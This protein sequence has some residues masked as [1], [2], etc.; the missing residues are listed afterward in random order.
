MTT[1]YVD[2]YAGIAG[3]MMLGALV[4][5]GV[6]ESVIRE[7][8][9]KIPLDGY[10][11]RFERVMRG[12]L[13]GT[14]A[15]VDVHA[16]AHAHADEHRR[17]GHGHGH[18][19]AH[20]GDHPHRHYAEIRAMLE[21]LPSVVKA[22]ARAIFDRLAAVEAKLHG[23]TVDEVAFH[24][25]G[26]VDSI[27]DIVGAAAGLAWLNPARV[28]V[29]R[30]P[31]G[32][33]AVKTAHGMLPVPAPATMALLAEAGALV[34]DGGLAVEL[35]TPTGAAILAASA[36]AYGPPPAMRVRA[37]GW[38]AGDRELADRPNLLRLVVGDDEPAAESAEIVEIAANVDDMNPELYEP[39]LAALFAAGAVDAW[40]TPIVMKKGRPAITVS[41]LA[42]VAAAPS[43]RAALLAE[44]TTLGVRWRTLARETLA[45]RIVEVDTRFGRV[46]V[47]LGERDG[48]VTHVAPEYE[49]CRTR[50]SEAGVPT[51]SVWAAAL[52]AAEATFGGGQKA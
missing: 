21:G 15:I 22:R 8:L 31:L 37:T 52:A 23:T 38:G 17:D 10:S 39:L 48:V 20:L 49:S 44:S 18:G 2:C 14:K 27:V 32:S 6:P 1:L 47:K 46:A 26:A 40:L 33:G 7:A 28:V 29:R 5:V 43:V 51:R 9:A 25:V 36:N 3:D 12:A 4:D 41:A 19:H 13:A 11:L 50:A 35:T 16:H 42:P 45:R 30:V 34:E 24:E